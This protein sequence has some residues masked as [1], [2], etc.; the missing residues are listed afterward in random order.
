M[1]FLGGEERQTDHNGSLLPLQ[2][3]PTSGIIRTTTNQR[4]K[5]GTVSALLIVA[6]SVN[7]KNE[8][9]GFVDIYFIGKARIGDALEHA[10]DVVRLQSIRC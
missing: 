3:Q 1:R 10:A 6:C 9:G 5:D 7:I 8:P 4:L 2:I